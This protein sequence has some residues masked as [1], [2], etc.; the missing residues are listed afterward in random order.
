MVLFFRFSLKLLYYLK[1]M[2]WYS[3]I[4]IALTFP[5][6]YLVK[7]GFFAVSFNR[8]TQIGVV[9]SLDLLDYS[10]FILCVKIFEKGIQFIQCLK[11][12]YISLKRC[13]K[14]LS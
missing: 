7:L 6:I 12:T 8:I 3:K 1:V 13:L 9:E 10:S 2:P 11:L 4:M 5:D 14:Y